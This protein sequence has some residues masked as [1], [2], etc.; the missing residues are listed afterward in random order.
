MNRDREAKRCYGLTLHVMLGVLLIHIVA[1]PFLYFTIVDIYKK[2]ANDQF[3]SQARQTSGMFLDF[4]LAEGDRVSGESVKLAM[5]SLLLGGEVLYTR[6]ENNSGNTINP[7]GYDFEEGAVFKEDADVGEH[8]DGVYFISLAFNQ[9]IDGNQYGVLKLGFDET[10]VKERLIQVQHSIVVILAAYLVGVILLLGYL[11]NVILKPLR[12]LGVWSKSVASGEDQ[13]GIS[14]STRIREVQS[15]CEDL[16]R[17]R[18]T[19]VSQSERMHYKAMHDELTGLPNRALNNDRIDQAISRADR[20]NSCFAIMLL[21]LD[22]F[23]VINDTLGHG[24][25]DDT[26]V[27]IADRLRSGVRDSDTVSRLG[28]DE[29]CIIIEGVERVV[30][31]KLAMKLADMLELPFHIGGHTLQ[32]GAS[33]GIAIYP[34]NGETPELLFQHADVAMYEAKYQGLKVVSYHSDM[35]KNRVED[36]QLASDMRDGL[37]NG[38]FY[39][40]FQPKIDLVTGKPCG[41]EMLTRWRHPELGLIS[42]D[43][44]IPIVEKENLIGEMTQTVFDAHLHELKQLVDRHPEFRVSINVS[45]YNLLDMSLLE[46]LEASMRLAEFPAASLVIEVTENAIMSN[47]LLSAKVLHR[48]SSRGI[49]ISVDD[50]GTGYS[51]LAYLQKFPID[52]LKIDKS[53]IM[54]LE[55]SSQ[56]YPIVNATITMAHDLGMTVIAE[57]VE[58]MEVEALLKELGCDRGQGMLY[59]RPVKFIELRR[60]LDGDGQA[61]VVNIEKHS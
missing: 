51:S 42:P 6:I 41:A 48:F 27:V 28:G 38:Q 55:K 59:A 34:E 39:A 57:G 33:I 23:K 53:F 9:I 15:L 46:N 45:P 7:D 29:F 4:L 22:R 1:M 36:L 12:H 25:G 21:D 24:A 8:G 30:A 31:E 37:R 49:G 26:L 32:V 17:M 58:T 40:V 61:R 18:L 19:L 5:E 2:N 16:E 47:P 10:V 14:L 11:T 35:D 44:F 13:T 43:K 60:W 52:E 56:N 20:S 50:F 3:V 54:S